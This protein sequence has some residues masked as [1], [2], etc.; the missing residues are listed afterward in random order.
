MTGRVTLNTELR[1]VLITSCHWSAR[2]R[3][4]RWQMAVPMPPVP[5]VTSA[6]RDVMECCPGIRWGRGF[7]N[8]GAESAGRRQARSHQDVVR[9]SRG[10]ETPLGRGQQR[11][12][13]VRMLQPV[14]VPAAARARSTG[15]GCVVHRQRCQRL[16]GCRWHRAAAAGASSAAPPAPMPAATGSAALWSR[17]GRRRAP[18]RSRPAR[19]RPPRPTGR[20]SNRRRGAARSRRRRHA[21]PVAVGHAGHHRSARR[22]PGT[23]KRTAGSGRGCRATQ[24]DGCRRW[25]PARCGCSGR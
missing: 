9:G 24:G 8:I 19:H 4:R 20:P 12:Q 21:R 22:C 18:L 23:R 10:V 15:T 3:W 1:L 2:M 25:R 5:P 13:V 16:G 7:C 14:P 11:V 6:T 17:A